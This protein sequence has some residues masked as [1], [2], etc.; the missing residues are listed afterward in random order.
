MSSEKQEKKN[1]AVGQR[2]R[3]NDPRCQMNRELVLITATL[4]NQR[5]AFVCDIYLNGKKHRRTTILA[6]RLKPTTTGYS[7]V[8][9]GA[10]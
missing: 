9:E 8:G 10:P 6:E 2:W 4:K 5:P 1:P 3:D 7:Y